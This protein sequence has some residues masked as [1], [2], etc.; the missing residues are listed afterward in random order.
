MMHL[1]KMWDIDDAGNIV[2]VS[3]KLSLQKIA[4]KI[5]I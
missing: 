3:Q 5:N 1:V 2:E 4:L